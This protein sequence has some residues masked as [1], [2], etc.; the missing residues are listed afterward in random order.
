MDGH[1]LNESIKQ[2]AQIGWGN[3]LRSFNDRDRAARTE[4]ND[5]VLVI[6]HPLTA[7]QLPV[8]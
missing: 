8:A 7:K 4:T 3:Q 2:R 6:S 5:H 1:C